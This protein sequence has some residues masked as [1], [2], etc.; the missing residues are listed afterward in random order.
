MGKPPTIEKRKVHGTELK[1]NED[2]TLV[3]MPDL[4]M[5]DLRVEGDKHYIVHFLHPQVFGQEFA[6]IR[7]GNNLFA[8]ANHEQ[9]DCYLFDDAQLRN[10]VAGAEDSHAKKLSGRR[11]P[12]TPSACTGPILIPPTR[13]GG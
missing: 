13:S 7:K 11:Q 4:D 5:C 1:M 8:M 9:T 6:A 2:V 10:I 3:H 12:G